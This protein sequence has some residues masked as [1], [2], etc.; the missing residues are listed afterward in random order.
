[1]TQNPATEVLLRILDQ[2]LRPCRLPQCD[3]PAGFHSQLDR[4]VSLNLRDSRQS[5]VGWGYE[6]LD[7][8][9][10]DRIRCCEREEKNSEYGHHAG[11]PHLIASNVFL[12]WFW[13]SVSLLSPA[14][15]IP[16]SG[17]ST[18]VLWPSS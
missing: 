10:R 3:L 14:A 13:M 18:P 9:L 15:R 8:K 11:T 4:N 7:A 16:A 6:A 2:Q 1:R 12:Q 5:R 17:R